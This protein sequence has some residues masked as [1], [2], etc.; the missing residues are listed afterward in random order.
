MKRSVGAVVPLTGRYALQGGQVRV[1]LELWAQRTGVHLVLA[2][3]GS[4]PARS[5][6]VF[7]ELLVRR[8]ELVLPPYGGD[9]TRAVAR[10]ASGS[11]VWNHGA[12]ADDVQ[13]LPGVVSVPTPASRYLVAL[14][15]AVAQLRPEA[16]VAV[17]SAQGPFGRFAREGFALRA[18][19]LGL[20]LVGCFGFADPP[21]RIAATSPDAVLACGPPYREIKLFR[22][23]APLLPDALRG[24]VSPGLSAFPM[25]L[26]RDPDGFL[27]P[28]QW[29]HEMAI[30]PHLGPTSAIVVADAQLAGHPGIDYVAA[31]AY[32]AALVA[33]RC[34]ELAPD[35]PLSVA[36]TLRTTTFF[37]A[38]ELDPGSGVQRG[39]HLAVIEWRGQRRHLLLADAAA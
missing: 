21:Q 5:V 27:A 33:K 28:V 39:H 23:L 7:H 32:A 31:Q 4:E 10:A 20:R 26:G 14:G 19:R 6:E 34:L 16:A 24:G 12:A 38:F 15:Q 35:D 22:A 30:A 8:C 2:D 3:D 36:R 11:V 29:H 9:S 1:G 25:L 37:G 17:V 13:R 18:D